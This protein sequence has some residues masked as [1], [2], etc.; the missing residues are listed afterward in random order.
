MKLCRLSVVCSF[1][2]FSVF[3]MVLFRVC[4]MLG[5]ILVGLSS[6]KKLMM[7]RLGRLILLVVGI[8]G[9]RG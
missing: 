7:V 9:K 5:G 8:F 6:V 2:D 1:F 3:F 4:M